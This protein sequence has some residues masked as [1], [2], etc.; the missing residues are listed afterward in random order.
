MKIH[1]LHPNNRQTFPVMVCGQFRL[2]DAMMITSEV[3]K[4]TCGHCLKW[5]K[6]HPQ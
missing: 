3:A 6:K 1:F 5:L 4:V 2:H